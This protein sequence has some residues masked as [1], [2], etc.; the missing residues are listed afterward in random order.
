MVKIINAHNCQCCC[1]QDRTKTGHALG[2]PGSRP[3]VAEP[4]RN[5]SPI[6]CSLVR[7]VMHAALVMG[8]SR[9]AKVLLINTNMAIS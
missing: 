8:A 5:L 4:Q 2:D 9:D 1:R 7:I 3:T 6:L